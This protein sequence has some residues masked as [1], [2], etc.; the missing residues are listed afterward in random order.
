MI[1]YLGAVDITCTF[2][3]GLITIPEFPMDCS[4]VSTANR[5]H[6]PAITRRLRSGGI[7][8]AKGY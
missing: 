8:M 7:T 3:A 1:L 2:E 6:I 5:Y 4:T